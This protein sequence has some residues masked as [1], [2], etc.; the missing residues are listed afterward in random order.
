MP[1]LSHIILQAVPA[2]L[3]QRLQMWATEI[4]FSKT[5]DEK[6]TFSLVFGLHSSW[7]SKLQGA[8][9]TL[10]STQSLSILVCVRRYFWGYRKSASS[11]HVGKQA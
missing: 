9:A 4:P 3:S 2:M 10:L 8:I 6:S 1:D 5:H 7:M 11:A